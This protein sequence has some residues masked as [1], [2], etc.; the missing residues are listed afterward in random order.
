MLDEL[1]QLFRKEAFPDFSFVGFGTSTVREGDVL[2]GELFYHLHTFLDV[3]RI[4]PV[5][6]CIEEESSVSDEPKLA[7]GLAAEVVAIE[8]GRNACI[9]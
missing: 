7:L 5:V 6:I 4:M 1:N 3:C 9:E 8:H 2:G